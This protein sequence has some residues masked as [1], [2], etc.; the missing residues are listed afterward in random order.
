MIDW[1]KNDCKENP[2]IIINILTKCLNLGDMF[3]LNRIKS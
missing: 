3:C 2:L 1:I